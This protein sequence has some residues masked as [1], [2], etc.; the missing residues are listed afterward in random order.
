LRSKCSK[1][2]LSLPLSLSLSL[3]RVGSLKLGGNGTLGLF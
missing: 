3:S 2:V 1:I